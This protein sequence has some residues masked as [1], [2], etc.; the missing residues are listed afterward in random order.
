MKIVKSRF[1][2]TA[3]G[4]IGGF[5]R[6]T[7]VIT[8][9]AFVIVVLIVF[10]SCSP[11]VSVSP[12]TA[13]SA[14]PVTDFAN[15]FTDFADPVTEPP[16]EWIPPEL[17]ETSDAGTAAD[18]VPDPAL[19]SI[20]PSVSPDNVF[21]PLVLHYADLD[22]EEYIKSLESAGFQLRRYTD[23]SAILFG[24]GML[25]SLS[26]YKRSVNFR[27][28]ISG[29]GEESGCDDA[30]R[31]I[32]GCIEDF[33][34]TLYE[35]GQIIG[36]KRMEPVEFAVDMTP[37]DFNDTDGVGIFVCPVKYEG[38]D[39]IE[40]TVF[41][42]GR[43]GAVIPYRGIVLTD[44]ET[45][46][47]EKYLFYD[48]DGDG[49]RD[50][51]V[52]TGGASSGIHTESFFI[53]RLGDK[54]SVIAGSNWIT[55]SGY[56]VIDMLAAK[57]GRPVV[58]AQYSDEDGARRQ[59]IFELVIEDGKTA[60][61][62][63]KGTVRSFS[64]RSLFNIFNT[65]L[66]KDTDDVYVEQN[67]FE[68]YRNFCL[69]DNI[70]RLTI[71]KLAVFPGA[72][73]NN[74]FLRGEGSDFFRLNS[75]DSFSKL[76]SPA[77]TLNLYT[78]ASSDTSG[79]R[80]YAYPVGKLFTP[81]GDIYKWD[82][83]NM[84]VSTF[85]DVKHSLCRTCVAGGYIFYVTYDGSRA[86]LKAANQRRTESATILRISSFETKN[87]AYVIGIADGGA[88]LCVENEGVY[89]AGFSDGTVKKI[90]GYPAGGFAY[91]K[92]V[93]DLLY[94][95]EGNYLFA[96][97][98]NGVEL[99]R[100]EAKGRYVV[101][102][103]DLVTLFDDRIEFRRSGTDSAYLTLRG[104]FG[105]LTALDKRSTPYAVCKGML[106]V[107]VPDERGNL[108]RVDLN[109]KSIKVFEGFFLQ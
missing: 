54:P 104:D 5:Y 19:S 80:E 98:R 102:G 78:A 23:E 85:I 11:S 25:I 49:C 76:T 96:L 105:P 46:S 109:E 18:P 48:M 93:D 75:D 99:F 4:A 3:S 88:Y 89:F 60:F 30:L 82:L 36:Y 71:E 68:G 97:N 42:V 59:D 58:T 24:S 34:R 52:F 106:Y 95:A 101:F 69:D 81:D 55:V 50:L 26:W 1:P 41:I 13:D 29:S 91:E 35:K 66:E 84:T 45:W 6:H 10:S 87:P 2:E 32:N 39:S 108:V 77:Y 16:S 9:T 56:S 86:V 40:A 51:V 38:S 7:A 37:P 79:F 64:K 67:V 92:C 12:D 63:E 44:T 94:L 21:A 28:F 62:N 15:P 14:D 20:L 70:D 107:A 43:E 61:R 47:H 33:T 90:Y 100:I 72:L 83:Y 65:N 74:L 73:G 8:A 53:Y 27:A 31:V 17:P 103:S 57:D 22:P